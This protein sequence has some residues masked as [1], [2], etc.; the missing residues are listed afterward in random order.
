MKGTLLSLFRRTMETGW[1]EAT[2]GRLA[3][4][5][6]AFGVIAVENAFTSVP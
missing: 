5:A 1:T 4:A 3:S 6:A 2:S